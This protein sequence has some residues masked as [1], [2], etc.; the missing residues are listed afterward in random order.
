MN[1]QITGDLG[2]RD[3]A[4]VSSEQL[5]MQLLKAAGGDPALADGLRT[6][7][8]Q[9]YCAADRPLG[10]SEKGMLLWLVHGRRGHRQ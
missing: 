1:E 5:R 4:E 8:W 10:P 9:E 7:G 3:I 2:S 6:A